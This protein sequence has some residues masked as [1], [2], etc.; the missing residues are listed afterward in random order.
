MRKSVIPLLEYT[1]ENPPISY[2]SELK[3]NG[4]L[5]KFL[6]VIARPKNEFVMVLTRS[7]LDWRRVLLRSGA[8]TQ[9]STPEALLLFHIIVV[10]VPTFLF[11]LVHPNHRSPS[12]PTS[13]RDLERVR[14]GD[15]I[16][17]PP[18]VYDS[19]GQ[20]IRNSRGPY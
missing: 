5:Q 15:L 3:R 6:L 17:K 10:G 12:S 7:S 18:F 4:L 16:P 11:T 9:E 20:S 8:P 2:L 1:G 19:W 13:S 14:R